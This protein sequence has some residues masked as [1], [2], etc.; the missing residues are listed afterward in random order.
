MLGNTRFQTELLMGLTKICQD[1]RT[2][3]Q[4]QKTDAKTDAGSGN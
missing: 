1:A 2:V 3:W 4:H